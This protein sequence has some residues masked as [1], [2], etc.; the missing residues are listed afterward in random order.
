MNL[1]LNSA[2][3]W[4]FVRENEMGKGER[5]A[6]VRVLCSEGGCWY[7]DDIAGWILNTQEVKIDN[8]VGK[9]FKDLNIQCD[10]SERCS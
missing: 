4:E 3:N 2:W 8:E 1:E 6:S 5:G 10:F 9:S 7:Y